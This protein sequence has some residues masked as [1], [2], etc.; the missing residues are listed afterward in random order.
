MPDFYVVMVCFHQTNAFLRP[1][2]W[3]SLTKPM[4]SLMKTYGFLGTNLWFTR[5]KPMVCF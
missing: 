5:N 3:Y 2:Q 1:N 4:V